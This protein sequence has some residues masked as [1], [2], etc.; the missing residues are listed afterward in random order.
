MDYRP[1]KEVE[2]PQMSLVI[3][4]RSYKPGEKVHAYVTTNRP[5]RPVLLMLSGGDIWSYKVLDTH[6]RTVHWTFD[7]NAGQSPNDYVTA[8][9]W[10]EHGL[11]AGN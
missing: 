10:G 5:Y 6:K 8:S 1:A 4:K 2:E 11:M 9:Q 7:T 3:D